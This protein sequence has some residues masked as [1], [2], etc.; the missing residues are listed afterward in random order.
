[1]IFFLVGYTTGGGTAPQFMEPVFSNGVENFIQDC[2]DDK[3][4]DFAEF[5]EEIDILEHG[6]G[7]QYEVG[8][9]KVFA[10]LDAGGRV[11]SG[12]RS[13]V[14]R[15]LEQNKEG[16]IDNPYFYHSVLEFCGSEASELNFVKHRSELLE[17]TA[18]SNSIRRYCH[19][20]KWKIINSEQSIPTDSIA[21][22]LVEESKDSTKDFCRSRSL[23]SKDDGFPLLWLKFASHDA[24]RLAL[25]SKWKNID[26]LY[27]NLAAD[28][29]GRQHSYW[30]YICSAAAQYLSDGDGSSPKEKG[31]SVR[32]ALAGD[33]L[34][35]R[36]QKQQKA[37]N[38][39]KFSRSLTR[40]FK[41][42]IDTNVKKSRT[43][44]VEI[45]M[46]VFF[47]KISIKIFRE[48]IL[49]NED[50]R[51]KIADIKRA[52]QELDELQ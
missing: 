13:Y 11:I 33:S 7:T 46:A 2:V 41:G 43:S 16:F 6:V 5:H 22:W 44:T 32:R 51:A 10:V 15:Y 38:W 1:M 39:H 20:E 34:Q 4:T 18:L 23:S 52:R 17:V 30:Y 35:G 48:E 27:R 42:E 29:E 49:E 9:Q 12:D 40:T 24:P 26:N 14:G 3:I 45:S 8:D 50:V 19:Q 28:Q 47:F 37:L 25:D 36:F 31:L 21:Y